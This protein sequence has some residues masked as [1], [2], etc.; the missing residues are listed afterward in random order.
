V[1]PVPKVVERLL[2]GER[3][4]IRERVPGP[5]REVVREVIRE[6]PKTVFVTKPV[7]MPPPRL[8]EARERAL[9]RFVLSLEIPANTLIPCQEPR[10][11]E[12]GLACG[13]AIT[14][15]TEI[16]EPRAGLFVPVVL[17]GEIAKPK[18]LRVEVKPEAM[19]A[20]D[21]ATHLFAYPLGVSTWPRPHLTSGISYRNAA[22][23]GSY[24]IRVEYHYPGIGV[25]V[26]WGASW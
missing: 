13:H 20:H 23:L 3:V 11:A 22:P 16:L 10:L 6:V 5:I 9:R 15:Q 12:G 19:A 24:E 25:S 4:V 14:F 18:E 8:E 1:Q 2:P 7:E 21:A 17:P 26:L